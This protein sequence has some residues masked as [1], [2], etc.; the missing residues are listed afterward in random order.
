LGAFFRHF[1][2]KRNTWTF[3]QVK[4]AYGPFFGKDVSAV[5]AIPHLFMKSSSHQKAACHIFF[6]RKRNTLRFLICSR[7][8]APSYNYFKNHLLKR[9]TLPRL[10][11]LFILIML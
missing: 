1:G 8:N 4:M 9:S 5:N 3:F 7:K 2:R 11:T 6:G 10:D